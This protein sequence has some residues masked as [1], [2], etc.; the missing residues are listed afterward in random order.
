MK[1]LALL[2]LALPGLAVAQFAANEAVN[3]ASAAAAAPAPPAPATQPAKPAKLLKSV[4]PRYPPEAQKAGHEGRVVLKVQVLKEGAVGQLEVATSSGHLALDEAALAAARQWQFA[5]ATDEAGAAIDSSVQVPLSFKLDGGGNGGDPK[6]EIQALFKQPCAKVNDEV[7]AYRAATPD[8]PL[9]NMQT[10][11]MT[12]GVLVIS[13]LG[14]K[15]ADAWLKL[16]KRLPAI[17]DQVVIDCAARPE[18]DY[19][20]VLAE[21]MKKTQPP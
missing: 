11:K 8:Q 9:R 1:T 15:N 12:G 16:N 10:F 19:E 17:F 21:A 2:L 18:A 5:P 7:A 20:E 6:S 13:M 14:G 4:P 3:A